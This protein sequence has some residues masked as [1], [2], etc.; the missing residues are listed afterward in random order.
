M[1]G[2]P[3][4]YAVVVQW[5]GIVRERN[6]IEVAGVDEDTEFEFDTVAAGSKLPRP[7]SVS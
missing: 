3:E 5:A 1:S 4:W 6:A 2:W 7:L